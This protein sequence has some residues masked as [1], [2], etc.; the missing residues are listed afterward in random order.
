M[1]GL[2][3]ND[4]D[5]DNLNFLLNTKGDDFADWYA[6]SDE[7]DKVYA[8]ELMNA[9]SRELKLRSELLEVEAKLELTG[10]G[11]ALRVI[12]RVSKS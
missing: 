4:W 2:I 9:Y 12:D 8:Q 5:R 10:Y 7:D 1:K 3:T 11:D 6:Q